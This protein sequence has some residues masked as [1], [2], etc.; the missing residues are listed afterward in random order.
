MRWNRP[1]RTARELVRRFGI[2]EEQV[3]LLCEQ[4]NAVQDRVGRLAEES[5]RGGAALKELRD[6][7]D[8]I[9]RRSMLRRDPTRVLF[10]VHLI[11][12]WDSYHEVVRAME[13]SPDFEPIVVSIPRRF[14]GAAALGFEEEVHLGLQRENVAHL[15]LGPQDLDGALQLVKSIEPDL[16]FRQSQW[17]A[18]IP[19]VFG[20]DRLRFAR[21]CLIPYETM[22]IVQNLPNE[23]TDNSAVDS[24]Y[25]RGAWVVFCANDLMLQMARRDGALGGGQFRVVGHPKAD[26]L[27]GALPAWPVAS[28]GSGSRR[29]RIAWSAH[30]SIGR[31]WTEFGAFPLMADDMVVWA[32]DCPEIEFVFLPHPALIPYLGSPASPMTRAEF[33]EWRAMWD[34]LPNTGFCAE[35]AYASVL[36]ASDLL[37]TDGLSLM[38]EY[39]ILERPLILFERDGHRP[40]NEIG[41]IAREGAHTVT[42]VAE[43]RAAAE[44]LLRGIADPLGWRQREIVQRLFGD[45]PSA[46]QILSILREMI[47]SERG[48][49]A[50]TD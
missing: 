22:N 7:V 6:S 12:A 2:L 8:S 19:A 35:G 30:H 24:P 1:L 3:A 25:Q 43:V 48:A 38:V 14:N 26:R 28:G 33:D 32:R 15:R 46:D 36:A 16:I 34:G 4:L 20:T 23:L 10:L 42:T 31:G 29:R 18:D 11:E 21:T 40:F 47:A 39:Q 9:A 27:R 50:T 41:E 44:R 45:E 17:D 37:V 13:A 5:A 49:G